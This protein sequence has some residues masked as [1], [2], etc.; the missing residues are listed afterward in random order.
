MYMYVYFDQRYSMAWHLGWTWVLWLGVA[1]F[2]AAAYPP[3]A[4]VFV[5]ATA[6]ITLLCPV[7]L[8]WIQRYKKYVCTNFV[9]VCCR[10]FSDCV[11]LTILLNYSEINGPWDEAVPTLG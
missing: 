8:K 6:S 11:Q 7:W 10:F 1:S 3:V 5:A 9:Y 2:L 4:V